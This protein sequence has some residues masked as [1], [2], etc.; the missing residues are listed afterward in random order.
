MQ[1]L[2]PGRMQELCGSKMDEG[3]ACGFMVGALGG[4]IMLGWVV[5]A[6][7]I[8]MFTPLV[9]VLDYGLG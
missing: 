7:F 8:L 4:A 6:A 9:C 1:T 2:S 5:P 3:S